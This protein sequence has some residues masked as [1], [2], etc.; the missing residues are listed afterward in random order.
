MVTHSSVLAWRIRVARGAWWATVYGVAKII[1]NGK[2]DKLSSSPA[3]FKLLS[4]VWTHY[5]AGPLLRYIF[6][7]E[8]PVFPYI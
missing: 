4:K 6:R 8:F 2:M 7:S 3:A 1:Q 5:C